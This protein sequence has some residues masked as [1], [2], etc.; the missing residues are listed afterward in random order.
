MFL[1][2]QEEQEAGWLMEMARR[3][4]HLRGYHS[5]VYSFV[6]GEP[7]EVVYKLDYRKALKKVEHEEYVALFEDSGW[8]HVDDY[9]GWH[10]F[11][12]AATA[13]VLPEIYS[14]SDSLLQKYK[15]LL[16]TLISC[17]LPLLAIYFLIVLQNDYV[18]MLVLK[19]LYPMILGVLLIC[20]LKTSLKLQRIKK[21]E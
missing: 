20:I 13:K 4:W 18:F 10:Y 16:T 19:I 14:D 6:Q 15:Q 5:F 12:S 21:R 2:W 3:G 17:A 7:E 8:T 11:K 9:M 1:T